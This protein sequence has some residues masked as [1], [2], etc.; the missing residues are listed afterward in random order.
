MRSMM[1]LSS[2]HALEVRHL[3]RVAGVD[4]R[5]EAGGDERT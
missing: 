4:E 2:W 5:L 3:R 1:S